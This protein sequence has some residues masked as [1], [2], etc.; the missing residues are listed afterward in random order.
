MKEIK[1]NYREAYVEDL[2]RIYGELVALAKRWGVHV[3]QEEALP[4]EER[5]AVLACNLGRYRYCQ[6]HGELPKAQADANRHA[7]QLLSCVIE[8]VLAYAESA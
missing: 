7:K 3:T 5:V 1:E 4:L 6:E 2:K 8:K